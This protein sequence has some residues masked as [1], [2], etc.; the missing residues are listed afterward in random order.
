LIENDD[1]PSA[2]RNPEAVAWMRR[3]LRKVT[4]FVG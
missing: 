2:H 3:L 1:R 4:F